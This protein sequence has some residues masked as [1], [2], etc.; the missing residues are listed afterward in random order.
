MKSISNIN[1]KIEN[2]ED[3]LGDERKSA[4]LIIQGLSALQLETI[5]SHNGPFSLC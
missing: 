4:N 1:Q 3:I 5:E 2:A